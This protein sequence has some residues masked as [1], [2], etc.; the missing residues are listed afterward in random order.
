MIKNEDE[1]VLIVGRRISNFRYADD[2]EITT[3]NEKKLQKLCEKFN[4]KG[5]HFGMKMNIKKTKAIVISK[6][7]EIAQYEIPALT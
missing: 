3:E 1:G 4:E 5:K 7:R 2:T 6:K